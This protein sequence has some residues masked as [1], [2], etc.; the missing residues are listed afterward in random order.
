[1]LWSTDFSIDS[2]GATADEGNK[3]LTFR[4]KV[5]ISNFKNELVASLRW[6]NE[7]LTPNSTDELLA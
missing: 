1:M 6:E 4:N 2:N 7:R 5:I 3:V